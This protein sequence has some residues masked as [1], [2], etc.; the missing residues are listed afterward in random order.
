[1]GDE[2]GAAG[3]KLIRDNREKTNEELRRVKGGPR[4]EKG[5]ARWQTAGPRSPLIICQPRS[6]PEAPL[7]LRWERGF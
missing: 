1:V 3:R 2:A 7:R 6:W 4:E 5:P